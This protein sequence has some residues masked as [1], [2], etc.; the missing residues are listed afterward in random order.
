LPPG[1]A[2]ERQWAA[3]AAIDSD[4]NNDNDND[5][6]Y[7]DNKRGLDGPEVVGGALAP[8]V[9]RINSIRGRRSGRRR[10]SI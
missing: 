9:S 7:H 6:N 8:L 2:G 4:S 3:P 10:E 5:N 1:L